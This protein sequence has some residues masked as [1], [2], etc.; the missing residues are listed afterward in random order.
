MASTRRSPDDLITEINVT[1]MVDVVLV[2]LVILMVTASYLVAESIPMELPRAQSG[3]E[4]A[5]PLTVS[6]DRD[7]T[8]YL[9]ARPVGEE[10]L[11]AAAR[12]HREADPAASAIIAADGRTDHARVVRVM[13]LLR[14]ERVTRFGINVTP[15]ELSP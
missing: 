10:E 12:R 15:E 11:R 3:E 6:I 7:G 13:D 2:L 9:D 4:S 5:A 14:Q 1:P 8:L